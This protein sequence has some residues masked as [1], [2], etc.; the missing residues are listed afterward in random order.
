MRRLAIIAVAAGLLLPASPAL[1]QSRTFEDPAG[2][3]LH[4]RALDITSY[5][6]ANRDH[7]LVVTVSFVRATRGDL[8]LWF[9]AR[10]DRRRE[11]ALVFSRH[12]FRGDDNRLRTIDGDQPCAGLAVA[13]DHDADT[14]TVR[15]P[16]RCFR[17]GDYGAV[18]V[19][20]IT[21]IGSDADYTPK[22]PR[23]GW[24]WGSAVGRG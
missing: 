16:S 5:R 18:R 12:R 10:G 11:Q 21:E 23:G 2:D 4:G 1:A 19:R 20:V 17:A 7:A 24:A 8:G 6:V 22:N 3:G 14:A 15:L 9:S 13:W